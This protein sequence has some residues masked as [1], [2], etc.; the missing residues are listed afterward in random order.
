MSK[1]MWE[2]A[3][4]SFLKYFCEIDEQ[5][6]FSQ[7]LWPKGGNWGKFNFIR[8]NNEINEVSL[9]DL[10][11][12][13]R[14]KFDQSEKTLSIK[15]SKDM[16]KFSFLE[17]VGVP[18]VSILIPT[19]NNIGGNSNVNISKC[20][21]K[22][23]IINWW[24]INSDGRDRTGSSPLFPIIERIS[25]DDE[26]EFFILSADGEEVACGAITKFNGLYNLWGLAT[27]KDFQGKGYMKAI[28]EM[29]GDKFQSEF[30][31]QVN[32][33]SPSYHYFKKQENMKVLN[34]ERRY[35]EK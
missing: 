10:I 4:K 29:L 24:S 30:T 12:T 22:D 33:D 3:E 15:S 14:N 9:R 27:R 17:E 34:T 25:K 1:M 7:Y 32:L 8:L 28:I 16:S 2:E 35:V 31:V 26:S 5:D 18:I 11:Q 20:S 21:N 19:L 6:L 13:N 23:E